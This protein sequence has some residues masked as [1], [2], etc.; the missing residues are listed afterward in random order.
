M[1]NEK[2]GFLRVTSTERRGNAPASFLRGK[3]Q[4]WKGKG[5]KERLLINK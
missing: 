3:L 4:I 2:S 1:I 5:E